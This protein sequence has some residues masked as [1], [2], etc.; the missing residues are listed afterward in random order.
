M[1]PACFAAP[2]A[3]PAQVST[4]PEFTVNEQTA[5]SQTDPQVA[6][7]RQ[8]SGLYCWDTAFEG[9]SGLPGRGI[10]SSGA[11]TGPEV[12]FS[13]DSDPISVDFDCSVGALPDGTFW[14]AWSHDRLQPQPPRYQ[15][16]AG[17]ASPFGSPLEV[18]DDPEAH[19]P[20]LAVDREGGFAVAWGQSVFSDEPG[21][22]SDVQIWARRFDS[23]GAPI[24]EPVP[25]ALGETCNLCLVGS[26]DVASAWD[27]RFVVVWMDTQGADGSGDGVFARR[28]GADGEPLGDPFVVSETTAGSQVYPAVA[29][30]RFGNFVVLWTATGVE[31]SDT[32]GRLFWAD[33]TPRTGEFVVNAFTPFPQLFPDVAMDADGH[34]V[35]V[36]ESVEDAGGR[37]REIYGRAFRSDLTPYGP[38]FH[39]NPAPEDDFFDDFGNRVAL[40]DS[41]LFLVGW[42]SWTSDGDRH[43]IRGARFVL[44]CV[45]DER[46]LCLGPGGRFQARAQWRTADAEADLAR[47]RPL[48]S[49]SGAF[50]FFDEE[51]LEL[52][53]K[54]LDGCGINQRHWIYAAGLT[55]VEALLLVTDTA[56]GEVWSH[57]NAL[58]AR[59]PPVQ[60]VGALASCDSLPL[61]APPPA[62][63]R[64]L[65]LGAAAPAPAAG[66]CV[67]DERR[68]CL[69]GGRFEVTAT[70][71]T[72]IGLAGE[73]RAR[74]L[75]D[76]SGALWF[77]WEENLELFVKLLDACD[78]FERFWVYAAGLTD[79]EVE[80]VVRDLE[81]GE[82]RSYRNPLGTPFEPVHDAAAFATCAP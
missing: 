11:F 3:S 33:G 81:T 13:D 58:L 56:T 38:D 60:D 30:D 1:L 14:A 40:S 57:D 4:G 12:R 26:L 62:A 80:L 42:S 72:A 43:G 49:E 69:L 78:P 16:L 68:L 6:I 32:L 75:T 71:D 18:V 51:N 77:F 21:E 31:S 20:R 50:S 15:R 59:F 34:W 64:P 48:T 41:G 17:D 66:P 76:E 61:A 22:P 9:A 47:A 8:G 73:A 24:S 79:V 46:T 27:G 23:G 29:A 54:V 35:A 10:D 55:D 19:Y 67:P 74:P 70:F 37:Y 5:A 82:S 25:I 2:G 39:V 53:V 28:F 63:A 65:E 36:W 52:F 44:P 7:S 45:P